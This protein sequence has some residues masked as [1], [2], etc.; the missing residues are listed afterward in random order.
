MS[1]NPADLALTFVLCVQIGA[2]GYNSPVK[3][4][5]KIDTFG[6]AYD[7]HGIVASL[8]IA[9][10]AMGVGMTTAWQRFLPEGP[11]AFLPVSPPVVLSQ[12]R[13]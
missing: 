3:T 6:W 12:R 10:E 8:Q 7:I 4:Y 11:I 13:A 9:P 5:S 2:D 1:S